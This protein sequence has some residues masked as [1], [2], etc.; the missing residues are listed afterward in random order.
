MECLKDPECIAIDIEINE[1]NEVITCYMSS[2]SGE[3][4]RLGCG[5]HISDPDSDPK[6]RQCYKLNRPSKIIFDLHD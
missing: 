1:R 2:G 3:H 6:K 5:P 4:F